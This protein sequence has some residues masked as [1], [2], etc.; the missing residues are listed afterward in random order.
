LEVANTLSMKPVSTWTRE[1]VIPLAKLLAGRTGVDGRGDN[2][3]GA[4]AYSMLCPDL[5][6]FLL[7]HSDIRGMIDPVYV[8]A[9]VCG[10]I[11]DFGLDNYP[12]V[13]SSLPQLTPFMKSDYIWVFNGDDAMERA[14]HLIGWL[15]CKIN[16]LKCIVFHTSSPATYF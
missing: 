9:N 5:D 2:F 13:G 10:E 16:G 4:S 11:P 1:D 8:V 12:P 7:K 14:L 15:Q 6:E 3:E